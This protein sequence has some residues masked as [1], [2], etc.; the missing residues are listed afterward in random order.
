MSACR[1]SVAWSLA[2][3]ENSGAT[4]TA[5]LD[6]SG[7]EVVRGDSAGLRVPSG[8][9]GAGDVC[10][11]G[12]GLG[13]DGGLLCVDSFS[14]SLFLGECTGEAGDA[15]ERSVLAVVVLLALVIT[16]PKG[17]TRACV[18]GCMAASGL[19]LTGLCE[20]RGTGRGPVS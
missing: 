15:G 11:A 4:T 17:G 14:D 2:R 13:T 16:R 5:A 19:E 9:L 1:I 7:G 18:R 6:S 12:G 8:L 10:A 20:S 3:R